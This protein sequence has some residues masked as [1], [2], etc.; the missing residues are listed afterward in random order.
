MFIQIELVYQLES[1]N[2][3]TI[4]KFGDYNL[5]QVKQNILNCLFMK[6]S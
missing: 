4:H 2:N 6:I 5:Y 3:C 1:F